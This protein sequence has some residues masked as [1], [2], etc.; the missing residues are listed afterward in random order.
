MLS[1]I[2]RFFI[3]EMNLRNGIF[4]NRIDFHVILITAGNSMVSCFQQK[5]FS[6]ILNV[7]YRLSISIK[8]FSAI[9]LLKILIT[10]DGTISSVQKASPVFIGF[11][12]VKIK[13][14]T[15]SIKQMENLWNMLIFAHYGHWS[16]FIS[17]FSNK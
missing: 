3:E 8:P 17:F 1:Q 4:Y 10:T 6:R 5:R 7:S 12:H 11:S 2:H 13:V 9:S 16:S 15:S 14:R